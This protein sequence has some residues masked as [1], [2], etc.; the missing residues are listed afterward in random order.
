MLRKDTPVDSNNASAD[1]NYYEYNKTLGQDSP[2]GDEIV[3]AD[4]TVNTNVLTLKVAPINNATIK[5]IRKTGKTWNDK[6]KSLAA[7]K[8]T[9]AKFLT[10]STIKLAR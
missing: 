8:S 7:S 1:Y 4:F 6:N 10:D 9:I 2:S 3:T 5:I